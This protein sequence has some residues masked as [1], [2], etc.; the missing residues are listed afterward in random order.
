M[1]VY[2]ALINGFGLESIFNRAPKT[3][4][5]DRNGNI[6]RKRAG[7]LLNKADKAFNKYR[8]H[9]SIMQKEIQKI[10]NKPE[11][12]AISGKAVT[13]DKSDKAQVNFN[14]D[15]DSWQIVGDLYALN[16]SKS[17]PEEKKV[18]RAFHKEVLQV[19]NNY[20]YNHNLPGKVE[21]AGLTNLIWHMVWNERT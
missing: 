5:D 14:N 18:I 2:E 6:S 3:T 13:F 17:S 4:D 19:C 8:P 1:G 12:K 16:I 7:K 9:A 20:L 21:W 11:Y 10:I 15:N